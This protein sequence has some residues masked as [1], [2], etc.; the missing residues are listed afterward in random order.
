MRKDDLTDDAK[1]ILL[2]C[3][4]LGDGSDASPL[5]LSEYNKLAEWLVD[6]SL[7]HI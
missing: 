2:L 4:R 3:A 7:I 1:A 6:L 5:T